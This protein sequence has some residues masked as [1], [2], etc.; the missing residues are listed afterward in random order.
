MGAD[1]IDITVTDSGKLERSLS[2]T[3]EGRG[4]QSLQA[5]APG[6]VRSNTSHGQRRPTGNAA[7]ARRLALMCLVLKLLVQIIRTAAEVG[8][9]AVDHG[10]I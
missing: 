2:K 6:R 1:D 4:P 10:W 8:H 7:E 9:G 3:T 5:A